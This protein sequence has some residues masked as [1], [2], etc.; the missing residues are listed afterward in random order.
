MGYMRPFVMGLQFGNYIF[1]CTYFESDYSACDRVCN[2]ALSETP[3]L[4]KFGV[5]HSH[6]NI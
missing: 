3:C 1:R 6:N 5:L 2:A 4:R